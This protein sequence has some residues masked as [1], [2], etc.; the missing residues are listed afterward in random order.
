M[1]NDHQCLSQKFLLEALPDYGK[2]LD[3]SLKIYKFI[4]NKREQKTWEGIIIDKK[5]YKYLD[6][7]GY[8]LIDFHFPD[9]PSVTNNDHHHGGAH[10]SKAN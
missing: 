8:S 3:E 9:Y 1:E 7:N 5:K 4:L 6:I 10:Q 2:D